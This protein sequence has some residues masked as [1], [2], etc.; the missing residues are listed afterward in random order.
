M[1][2]NLYKTIVVGIDGTEYAKNVASTAIRLAKL[3]DAKLYA[4]YVS[5]VSNIVPT[6]VEWQLVAENLKMEAETAFASIREKAE[7]LG[8]SCETVS[9]SGSAAQELVQYANQVN[10]DLIVVGAAGKKAIERL[11]LGSVSEKVLRTAKQNVL[12]IR[13]KV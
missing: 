8:V 6:S 2:E 11:L 10:A 3:T 13:S 4:V 7:E 12:V 5:D 1:T 9:L